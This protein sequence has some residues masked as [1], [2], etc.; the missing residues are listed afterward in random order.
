[1]HAERL[2]IENEGPRHQ[3]AKANRF[4]GM[5][6]NVCRSSVMKLLRVATL[7][8]RILSRIPDFCKL[9]ALV[10]YMPLSVTPCL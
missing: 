1:M 10:I 4:Y 9:C 2:N 3:L 6:H 5:A 8:S 7:A